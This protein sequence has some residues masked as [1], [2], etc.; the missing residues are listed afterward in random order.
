MVPTYSCMSA[1]ALSPFQK[2]RDEFLNTGRLSVTNLVVTPQFGQY[3][4][5]TTAATGTPEF[6]PL[7][8]FDLSALL[9][10]RPLPRTGR[11]THRNGLSHL[12]EKVLKR[13]FDEAVATE[14]GSVFQGFEGQAEKTEIINWRACLRFCPRN[15]PPK[16]L[17]QTRWTVRAAGWL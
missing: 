15:N 7:R 6:L 9:I 8:C 16:N 2:H 1:L 5:L 4:S 17:R 13:Y 14:D 10:W 11:G 3:R 12:L